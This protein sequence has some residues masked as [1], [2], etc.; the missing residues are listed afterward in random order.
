MRE[1]MTRGAAVAVVGVAV[2]VAVGAAVAAAAAVVVVVVAA[3]E[4]VPDV[5]A[6]DRRCQRLWASAQIK[7]PR[8]SGPACSPSVVE[9]RYDTPRG[10][11]M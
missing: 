1:A 6:V 3:A 4:E 11:A 9:T 10:T 8:Y 7:L 5:R 2:V